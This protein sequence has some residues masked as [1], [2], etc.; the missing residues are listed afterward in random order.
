M[1][2]SRT[3][4]SVLLT[5]TLSGFPLITYDLALGKSMSNKNDSQLLPSNCYTPIEGE[6]I[7]KS[8][9]NMNIYE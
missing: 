7:L 6:I 5:K 1:Q 3:A 2:E 4:E 9:Q 8:K